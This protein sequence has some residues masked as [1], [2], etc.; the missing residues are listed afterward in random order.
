MGP[1]VQWRGENE[2]EPGRYGRTISFGNLRDKGVGY[3]SYSD[4]A[5]PGVV[6][7]G[8][9]PAFCDRLTLEGFTALAPDLPDEPGRAER[10]VNAAL[11][12]L[13]DNWHPRI[14]IVAFGENRVLAEVIARSRTLDAVAVLA[15][16]LDAGDDLIDDLRY[17]LS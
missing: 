12:H 2:R 4:R 10:I 13:V 9:T 15:A 7:L 6:V 14:G 8:G 11:D 16:E 1:T 17:D 3:M 5:G